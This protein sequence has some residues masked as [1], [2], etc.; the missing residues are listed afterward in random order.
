MSS[1][2]ER[3]LA[4]LERARRPGET[5]IVWQYAGAETREQAIA[6]RF[7]EGAP[8]GARQIV[9][10]WLSRDEPA[11]AEREAA[12]KAWVGRTG[13]RPQPMPSRLAG[14]AVDGP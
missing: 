7:P 11:P 1:D 8:A 4:R 14:G 12:P 9:V 3:R 10:A 13:G 2:R 5:F 6:R